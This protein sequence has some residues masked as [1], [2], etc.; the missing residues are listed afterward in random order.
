MGARDR[1][2]DI[3]EASK[4]KNNQVH[5]ETTTITYKKLKLFK[6]FCNDHRELLAEIKKANLHLPNDE[7]Q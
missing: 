3:I 4:V 2:D 7:L 5:L 1:I 6:N